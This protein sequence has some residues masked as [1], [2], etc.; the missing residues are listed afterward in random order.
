Y[1]GAS[2][3]SFSIRSSKTNISL[4]ISDTRARARRKRKYS[5]LFSRSSASLSGGIDSSRVLPSSLQLRTILRCSLPCVQAQEGLP[6]FRAIS[7]TLP[8]TSRVGPKDN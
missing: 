1:Q 8:L 3:R 2:R 5:W 6:H 7:Y 4:Q